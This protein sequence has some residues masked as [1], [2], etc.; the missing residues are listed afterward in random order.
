MLM[1]ADINIL[2]A[3]YLSK[4]ARH[5]YRFTTSNLCQ[6]R[7]QRSRGAKKYLM[8]CIFIQAMS[9]SSKLDHTQDNFNVHLCI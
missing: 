8:S 4:R 3:E 2:L 7:G 6:D 1:D 5:V 9:L